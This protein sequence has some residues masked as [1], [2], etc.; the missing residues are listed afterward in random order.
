MQ[1]FVLGPVDSEFLLDHSEI[2]AGYY[3]ILVRNAF[4]CYRTIMKEVAFNPVMGASLTYRDSQ[5]YAYSSTVPDENFAREL[6]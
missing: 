1:I 5:S 6:M 4:G 2:W 3:D